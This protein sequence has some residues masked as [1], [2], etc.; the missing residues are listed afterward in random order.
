MRITSQVNNFTLFHTFP[1]LFSST[2]KADVLII[3]SLLA[4]SALMHKLG[5][6]ACFFDAHYVECKWRIFNQRMSFI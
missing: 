6:L 2:I 4:F 1:I 3:D 5:A